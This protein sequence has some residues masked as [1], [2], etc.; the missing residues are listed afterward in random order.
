MGAVCS[1]V[2]V[3]TTLTPDGRPHGTTV[4]SFASLSMEPP[5]VSFALDRGSELLRHLH[6]SG[7]AGINLLSHGQES[8]AVTFA[9]RGA[10]KFE[11]VRWR[12]ESGVPRLH[13]DGGWIA[14]TVDNFV[15]GG[16]HEMI[17]ARVDEAES[18]SSF[19]LVYARRTF[20]THS[21]FEQAMDAP[22]AS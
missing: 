18:S 19:P 6:E 7:R 17:L 2:T 21:R 9:R 4:S 16:D 15:A 12:V 13:G 8:L 10:D 11:D 14:V 20:G 1:P 5:M 22:S 3:I